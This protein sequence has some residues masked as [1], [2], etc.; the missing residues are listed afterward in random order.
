MADKQIRK[1]SLLLGALTGSFGV[2]ISKILGLFYVVP[3]NSLAGEGNMVFYSITYTYYDLLL[4][5]SS[6]GIPFAIAALVAKYYSREDYKTVLLIKKMGSSILLLSGF[7]IAFL[8]LCVS[9]PLAKV[10]MGSMASPEDIK[11]LVNLFRILS[12]ALVLVPFLSSLRGYY[13]GLKE[14]E[15]YAASQVLEQFVRVFGIIFLGFVCV[16]LLKLDQIYAIYM[17]ILS[18]SIGA[19]AA[20]VYFLVVKR[21]D[22]KTMIKM[23]D[24]QTQIS[25][26]TKQDIFKE[27]LTLGIPYLIISFLGVTSALID[28]NFFIGYATKVGIPYEEAKLVLGILQV[29]CHKIASIPQVLTIGFS[30]GLVPYI[31]EAFEKHDYQKLRCHIND[32]LKTVLFILIPLVVWIFIYAKPIYYIMYGN[33]NLDMAT[34][35]F[36]LSCLTIFT[37]TIA[38]IISSTCI[39]LRQNKVTILS[40]LFGTAIKLISFFALIKLFGPY[41]LILSTALASM[42]VIL[43]N[44]YNLKKNFHVNYQPLIKDVVLT[45]IVALIST[46]P[47]LLTFVGFKF[48]YQNRLLCIFILGIYGLC[49]LSIYVILSNKLGLL[50]RALNMDLKT[51]AKHVL[52]K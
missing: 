8:F 43:I 21:N 7:I 44:L 1:Q 20:I 41:G 10:A 15:A 35:I 2:F 11:N 49:S 34:K 28:S 51:A 26:R 6:A 42:V 32:I 36:A 50:K 9:N 47:L 40:L 27:M 33:A 46:V 17:A 5:I 24:C 4:K 31:T 23:A 25:H 38:P 3:L 30:A 13:Q 22:D 14:M 48:N 37:D 18:A 29:N 52:H 16:S 45:L 39:T 19:L 12:L